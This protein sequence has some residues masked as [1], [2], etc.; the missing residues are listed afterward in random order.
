[1]PGM[2]PP[3]RLRTYPDSVTSEAKED[4]LF[5][6]RGSFRFFDHRSSIGARFLP[7]GFENIDFRDS[8]SCAPLKNFERVGSDGIAE[9]DKIEHTEFL[10]FANFQTYF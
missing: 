8:S 4:V 3:T 7:S 1:M 6:L 9:V 2:C 10:D 5:D